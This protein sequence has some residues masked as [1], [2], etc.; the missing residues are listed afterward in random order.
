[1][2]CSEPSNSD[3]CV[4]CTFGRQRRLVHREAVVLA[5]DQH[6]PAVDIEHRVIRAVMTELHLHRLR[7]AREAEQLV[8]EA[9][10]EDR[11]AG[12]EELAG[13]PRSRRC[14]APDRRGRWTGTRRRAA[15]P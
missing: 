11:H 15:A 4:A 13:S 5:R 1:M 3:R 2:P 9:D 6:A 8:A 7:A 12:F 14:T 10:A